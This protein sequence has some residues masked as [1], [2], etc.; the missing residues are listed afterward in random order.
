MR[1]PR[2]E[3]ADASTGTGR[4]V[5]VAKAAVAANANISAEVELVM[6]GGAVVG[7]GAIGR[8][9]GIGQALARTVDGNR[10]AKL[11]ARP[12]GAHPDWDCCF[13]AQNLMLAAHAQGLATCPIGLAWPLFEQADVK[14]ELEIPENYRVVL[15]IIVGHPRVPA[16]AKERSNPTILCW[17]QPAKS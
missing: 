5:Q 15:P 7:T 16:P 1:L 17:R 9:Y 4:T 3:P 8:I 6:V 11:Q 10:A 2:L 14:Q 12:V 13:A